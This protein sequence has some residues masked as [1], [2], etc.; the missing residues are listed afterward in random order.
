MAAL[1]QEQI[2]GSEKDLVVWKKGLRKPGKVTVSGEV[3]V[4]F[5]DSRFGQGLTNTSQDKNT[6]GYVGRAGR[7]SPGE[8]VATVR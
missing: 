4:V 2:R 3:G 7:G 8:K 1:L 5:W 6:R